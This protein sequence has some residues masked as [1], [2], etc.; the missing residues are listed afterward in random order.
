[1]TRIIRRELTF[2]Q[3]PESVWRALTNSAALAE[4]MYPNDFEPRVGH[5][6]TFRVPSM[7]N[8]KRRPCCFD[9]A[10]CTDPELA[11]SGK[12]VVD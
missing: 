3:S 12:L 9:L 11:R 5:Q 1:M 10:S 6:F 7:N 2:L 8:G 4:W